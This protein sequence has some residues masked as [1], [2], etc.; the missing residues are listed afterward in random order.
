MASAPKRVC[1]SS[2][3]YLQAGASVNVAGSAAGK[4]SFTDDGTWLMLLKNS[5]RALGPM[6]LGVIN[7]HPRNLRRTQRVLAGRFLHQHALK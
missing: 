2:G 1:L 3:G 6:I 4:P 5:L 7:H